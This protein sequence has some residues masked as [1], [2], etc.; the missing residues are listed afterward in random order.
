MEVMLSLLW[1]LQ[2]QRVVG[3]GLGC[4]GAR[5]WRVVGGRGAL[6]LAV[7]VVAGNMQQDVRIAR[8]AETAR[9]ARTAHTA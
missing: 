5:A 2:T 3:E 4:A 7:A 6:A 8:A 1:P 9:A